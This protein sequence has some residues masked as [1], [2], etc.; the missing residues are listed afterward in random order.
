[1]GMGAASGPVDGSSLMGS[2]GE[3]VAELQHQDPRASHENV[4]RAYLRQLATVLVGL[5]AMCDALDPPRVY[6]RCV[7]KYREG[8]APHRTFGVS[9]AGLARMDSIGRMIRD[10]GKRN[11]TGS[12]AETGVWRG[13]MSIY[14]TA[15][16]QLHGMA[17][18]PVYV[19]DSFQGLPAPRTGSLRARSDAVYHRQ[20]LGVGGVAQVLSNFDHYGVP[21]GQVVPVV[22]F[23]VDSMPPL[24]T[25]LLA[26]GEKLAIL[27][28]D[29]DMYDSTVDVLYNVYDLVQ[30]GGY[31]VIDD[32]G[33]DPG[34]SF[35]ARYAI[36]DFR[37]LHGIEDDAHA[38]RNIDGHAAWFYKAREVNL[39]RDLYLDSLTSNRKVGRQAHLRGP[40][41]VLEKKPFFE[42][43]RLWR[44]AWTDE[45]R[46]S[47]DRVFNFTE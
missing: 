44:E 33:W 32:F 19:C 14:A 30:V 18:R 1:M 7:H 39:R 31:I 20:K 35:G 46:A 2:P 22:G 3:W 4:V 40:G 25:A 41:A 5:N 24:R 11:L 42:L 16:L 15:A 43:T 10:A 9:M 6:A 34:P 21:R 8:V 13:G 29:G 47:A 28:L 38:V 36:M 17:T 12:Y 23:F 26:K 27:R 37:A 45:E